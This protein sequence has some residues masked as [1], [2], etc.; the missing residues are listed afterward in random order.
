MAGGSRADLEARVIEAASQ[1]GTIQRYI[2]SEYGGEFPIEGKHAHLT[3]P[4]IKAFTKECEVRHQTYC[5]SIAESHCLAL[6]CRLW[7]ISCP[8][9]T[10]VPAGCTG[11]ASSCKYRVHE[12]GA[13]C[14]CWLVSTCLGGN[15]PSLARPHRQR[16]PF[17]AMA[18]SKVCPCP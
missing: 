8:H 5:R 4:G 3:P 10:W 17:M 1:A 18:M 12:A 6:F 15:S 14:F 2:P 9:S 7:A 11:G 16:L 13:L